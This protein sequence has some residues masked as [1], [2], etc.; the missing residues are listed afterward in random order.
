MRISNYPTDLV[1]K[2][3]FSF[4]HSH[5]SLHECAMEIRNL[6]EMAK[7]DIVLNGC[8]EKKLDELL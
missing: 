5:F 8:T 3:L 7:T 2:S 1:S 4:I 6:K